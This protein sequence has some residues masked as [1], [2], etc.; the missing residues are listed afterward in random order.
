MVNLPIIGFEISVLDKDEKFHEDGI[1]FRLEYKKCVPF[2]FFFFPPLVTFYSNPYS[3]LTC[4][5]CLN[6]AKLSVMQ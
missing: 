5:L 1:N 3:D 6:K 2:I 4:I